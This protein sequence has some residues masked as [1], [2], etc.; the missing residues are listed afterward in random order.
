M[1][2]V[3][4]QMVMLLRALWR[5]GRRQIQPCRFLK[6]TLAMAQGNPT[7]R[8]ERLPESVLSSITLGSFANYR[9]VLAWPP[10]RRL[11]MPQ[12]GPQKRT[13]RAVCLQTDLMTPRFGAHRA[14]R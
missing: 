7:R 4:T 9:V 3:P 10:P 1:R 5:Q 8:N 14:R 2:R 6:A 13:L 11:E 12:V